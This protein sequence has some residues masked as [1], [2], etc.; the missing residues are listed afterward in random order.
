MMDA[1][2][3]PVP[4]AEVAWSLP[5]RG[6][7]GMYCLIAAEAAIFTIF[8]VAYLFYVGK[9]LSGPM[10]KDVLHL[11]VAQTVCLLSSSISIH[12]AARS[13]RDGR[14]GAFARWWFLTLGLG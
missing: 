7:F 10:P 3:V 13:L 12:F 6:R 8:V 5:D 1:V 2:A 11:P 14:L 4:E 9:S